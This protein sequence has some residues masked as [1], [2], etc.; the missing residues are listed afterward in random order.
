MLLWK[1]LS[2]IGPFICALWLA[3]PACASDGYRH[4]QGNEDDV[5]E[6]LDERLTAEQ[7]VQWRREDLPAN[8]D[9]QSWVH[10]KI[11]GI[12]DFHGQLGVGRRVA[13]RPVGSA[14]VLAAYLRAEM[15]NAENSSILVHAGDHVGATPPN[16]A[17][18]QDEP[19]IHFLNLLANKHCGYN[20]RMNPRCNI[21]GT[22]GNHEFDEGKHEMLRLIFGGNHVDGPFL[23]DPYRGTNFPYISANVEEVASGKPILPPYVI[24]KIRGQRVAFIGAVLKETPTIVTPA[25][26]VGVQFIDE[27]DAI[28]RYVSKLKHKGVRAIIVLI[29]QGTRQTSY[30]GPTQDGLP[31]LAGSIGDIVHRLDDEVDIVVS[32]HAHSFTNTL[33]ANRNGKKILVTQAFSSSTAYADIDV[34]LDPK[35]K[36]IVE[37]SAAIITTW[38]DDPNFVPAADVAQLVAAADMRVAPLVNRVIGSAAQAITRVENAGGESALGNLIAD[39]QRTVMNSDFAFMNPGGIRADIDAG[40]V[41]W[42]ELF[43]VQPFN[44]DL[45]RM[46]LTGAQIKAL[47]EQQWQGQIGRILKV[48]GL[49]YTWNAAAPLGSRIVEIHK[50]DGVPLDMNATFSVTVNSF[51]AGGGDS[52]TVLTQGTNRTVGP[53]DLDAL[54]TYL[55]GLTQP[56]S[57]EIEGRILRQN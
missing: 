44:N 43:T 7:P 28:N 50:A 9:Q 17:L 4:H 38:A 53:V 30:E 14:P 3:L 56:F 8:S 52:F 37:K 29:H 33:M 23:E 21:V 54:V 12:N 16:S 27:A 5:A 49:G 46:N 24:K 13:N 15:A 25:G 18:L 42:G 40:E 47:L 36:D 20:K 34:A 1:H 22:P 39:A 51:I 57:A 32:G 26:V 10:F 31:P 55:G 48:S 45:V 11:L 19:S 6:S 35:T 2:H 41:L